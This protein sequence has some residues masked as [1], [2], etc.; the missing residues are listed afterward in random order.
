MPDPETVDATDLPPIKTGAGGYGAG[1]PV[2]SPAPGTDIPGPGD[3]LSGIVGNSS[4]LTGP[5]G[6]LTSLARD[7]ASAM[8]RADTQLE[9]RLDRDRSER[10]RAYRQEAAGPDSLP[11][12]WDA[13]AEKAKNSTKPMEAFG[14]VGMIFALA[15]SAFTKTPMTSAL[16]AGGAVLEAIHAGDEDRYKSAYAAWKDNTDLALKRFQMERELFDDANKLA[17][18]DMNEWAIKQKEIAGRFD[19]K[20]ALAMLE[21]GLGPQVLEAQTAQVKAAEQMVEYKDKMEDVDAKMSILRSEKQAFMEA[22]GITD[23]KD[24]R[25]IHFTLAA[26]QALNEPA[27]SEQTLLMKNFRNDFIA[28]NNR[29]PTDEEEAKHW[30]EIQ[31]NVSGNASNL[32]FQQFRQETMAATGREP[33]AQEIQ[34]FMQQ[35]KMGR[36]PLA[37]A[38][39]QFVAETIDKTGKPP[40]SEGLAQFSA[41]YNRSL[42]T[43]RDYAGSGKGAQTVNSISV[44]VDHLDTLRQLADALKNKNMPLFNQLSQAWAQQNGQAAPTNFDAARQIIG[45]EIVKAVVS[46]GGGVSERNAAQSILDKKLSPQQIGGAIDAIEKL[47][48]G[49]LRGQKRTYEAGTTVNGVPRTDFD[50]KL[51]PRAK[52]VLGGLKGDGETKPTGGVTPSGVKWS[53]EP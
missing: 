16:K 13:A 52:E 43:S 46:G 21:A 38:M 17:T 15:A 22:N 14:S 1:Q 30:K 32:A 2:P 5:G 20:A 45:Q 40:S 7:R 10:D 4:A 12:K 42:K 49:Q 3:S 29:L 51:S 36:S 39:S 26:K 50:E 11:P 28:K 18:T 48:A 41:E 8:D 53:I 33:T 44:A 19:N 47:M 34:Q 27:N 24:L 9:G 25:V 6:T 37:M 31:T 23:P 35:G